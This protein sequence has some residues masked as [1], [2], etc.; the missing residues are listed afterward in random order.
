MLRLFPRG[1]TRSTMKSIAQ[2]PLGVV[3]N[4]ILPPHTVLIA[5]DLFQPSIPEPVK[6]SDTILVSGWALSS[7]PVK[8][9]RIYVDDTF[10]GFA[11]YH[12]PRPDVLQAYPQ[13]RNS[14]LSGFLKLIFLDAFERGLHQLKIVAENGVYAPAFVEGLI[15]VEETRHLPTQRVV[16]EMHNESLSA[17]ISVIILTKDPPV[18]FEQTIERLRA[19]RGIPKPEIVIVNSGNSNLNSLAKHNVRI[20]KIQPAEFSHSV[21]RNWAAHK[22]RGDYIMFLSDDAIP[23]KDDLLLDMVSILEHNNEVAAVTAR[24]LPRSDSDLMSCFMIWDFYHGL[25]ID[26]D[27]IVGSDNLDEITVEQKRASCQIDD[28]CSCYNRKMFMKYQ[29]GHSASYAEDLD[30]GIRLVKDGFKIARLFSTGVTHSHNRPTSYWL[31]RSYVDFKTVSTLLEFDRPDF[32]SWSPKSVNDFIDLI[33]NQYRALDTSVIKLIEAAYCSYDIDEA[34]NMLTSRLCEG[35]G[36]GKVAFVDFELQ[37][38][39]KQ[40]TQIV[41]YRHTTNAWSAS[42]PFASQY[43][44]GLATF[45]EWLVESHRTLRSLESEF[46]KALYKLLG[47]RI[48]TFLGE[49]FVYAGNT[50]NVENTLALDKLLSEGI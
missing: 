49:F 37:D 4:R 16:E 32:G 14:Q 50:V 31:K 40:I 41:N 10:V 21:T 45:R 29:Y 42:N 13:F 35:P 24:Q 36:G 25:R 17:R 2:Q 5:C 23:A 18:E 38:I 34:F 48:G 1:T 30:L 47:I 43:L 19:Q 33:L 11:N 15:E 3:L 44:V 20:Y 6:M 46:V 28:V 8:R 9:I 7:P 12:I 26:R 27:K 22:A 39:L